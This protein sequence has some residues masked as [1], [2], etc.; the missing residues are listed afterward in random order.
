M[1]AGGY[2]VALD[3][4]V[5]AAYCTAYGCWRQAEKLLAADTAADPET[6]GL[7]VVTKHGNT[8][9]NALVGIANTS[10]RDMLEIWSE[11]GLTRV[12]RSPNH[13]DAAA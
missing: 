9:Q 1:H 8:I 11:C 10:M 2:V 5:L 3:T 12:A 6:A 13:A 4:A 7:V